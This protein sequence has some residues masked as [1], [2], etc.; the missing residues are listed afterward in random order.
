VQGQKS[1]EKLISRIRKRLQFLKDMCNLQLIFYGTCSSIAQLFYAGIK[2]TSDLIS[3]P[4]H[5]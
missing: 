1:H 2:N 3:S 4:L 5:C